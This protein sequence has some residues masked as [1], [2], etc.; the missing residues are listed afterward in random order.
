MID[1][2]P[3][4]AL[5][6]MIL[7]LA[8][9]TAGSAGDFEDAAL[10][11]IDYPDWFKES[12]L[13]LRDDLGEARTD[14]KLG[15]MVLFTTEGCSYCAEFIRR[16]LGDDAIAETLRSGFDAVGLE[17]FSDAEMIAPDGIEM[18]VKAFAEREG[19]GFAPTLLFYGEGGE[20]LYRAVGYQDPERFR[21]LL[22]YLIGGRYRQESFRDYLAVRATSSEAA[23]SSYR[24]KPDPLFASPPYALDRSRIPA[25][26]PLLVIFESDD[27]AGCA[28]FHR[29]VLAL[30]E[31]RA[32]MA[33]F[34]VVRLDAGD[35]TTP[36]LRPDG[37]RTTPMDW[38][39]ETGMSDLPA[40]LFFD[41]NGREVL[42]T[43]ALVLRQRMMNS[44]MYTLER[45]YEKQWSY[46]RFARSKA[47]ERMQP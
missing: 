44:L 14:G 35:D 36:V 5:S 8:T 7:W 33:D 11:H 13:D 18:R 3:R 16:S 24:L 10:R 12:F 1:I 25:Q 45:A 2:M 32:P 43:D 28:S 17:I 6:V 4:H 15:L 23:P 20:R 27:C 21:M 19:A 31:V 22:D 42:R 40:L 47:L 37:I 9:V 30:P 29:E 38:Y 39:A 34:E 41:E 26:H 46:Q